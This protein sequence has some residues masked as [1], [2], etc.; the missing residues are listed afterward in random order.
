MIPIFPNRS[1]V[2][3]YSNK[4]VISILYFYHPP[5]LCTVVKESFEVKEVNESA[6]VYPDLTRNNNKETKRGN[7]AAAADS[8]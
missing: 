3:R 1:L 2:N 8:L 5:T 7:Y 6:K 4:K